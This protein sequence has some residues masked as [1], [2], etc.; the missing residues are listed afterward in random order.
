MAEMTGVA[1]LAGSQLWMAIAIPLLPILAAGLTF[2]V[3]KRMWRGGALLP[4]AAITA[5]LGFSVAFF[6]RMFQGG[7]PLGWETE[8]FKVAGLRFTVGFLLDNLAVWLM[9]IVSLLSLLITVFSTAYL[10]D[11]TDEHLRRYYAVKALFVAGM[12]GTVVMDNYL[13]M[14]IFWEV[15]G[16]C[17]Y[18][19]IGYW[20]T[21]E[22]AA[23]AAKKAFLTTRLGDIFL[24]LGIILLFT[25]FH[26]FSYRELF[27]HP[28]LAANK[29]ILFWAGL[30]IFGGAVGKSAQFPLDLWLPDAMEGP[31]TVSALIHAATMV[32][33]GVYLV[34][35]SWPLLLLSGDQ[36]FLVI[37][38]VGGFTA[39]YTASMAL[40]ATDIK[41][42]L[43]FST[44]SQ[45]GYMFLALGAGG[46]LFLH[47]GSG[48]GFTAALLH[49]MNHAFFK[50][51]LFLGSASVILGLHHHQ[52][53]REMGGLKAHMPTTHLTMLVGSL[54]IAGIIPLS[55]FWSK[56]EVLHTA[57]SVGSVDGVSGGVHAL[58][59]VLWGM[60]ILTAA[61]TAFYMFRMMWLTF[62]GKPRSEHA[63][64]AH[65]SPATMTVPLVLLAVFA[66]VSGLWLIAGNGFSAI[67][68]YPYSPDLGEAELEGGSLLRHAGRLRAAGQHRR[69]RRR[70]PLRLV[71]PPGHRR[72]RQR[73]RQP[74]R[75]RRRPRPALAGRP[76]LDLHG[77]HRRRRHAASSV[78]ARGRAEVPVVTWTSQA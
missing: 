37:G 19:L 22:S 9:T 53:L 17:S 31:T 61:L 63:E 65:E 52:D 18:L 40:A 48:A 35:R 8:W 69:L 16:V 3:G 39:L 23:V 36:L 30:F 51:L 20:Y 72:R 29:G 55:G 50:A 73:H 76:P 41:R 24:F 78:A 33:A 11:E 5:S 77:E 26:T 57:F 68:H 67:I 64:H 62:Y 2:L 10:R 54:S 34:A 32:K 49:L 6:V 14:F 44:L 58:F 28:D 70:P 45:L 42:V 21:R 46:I 43:A 25:T 56:D 27:H 60:G 1:Q 71:R 4:I 74:D 15:M 7:E 38:L 47:T 12:L 66:A 13:L 59:F 75:P